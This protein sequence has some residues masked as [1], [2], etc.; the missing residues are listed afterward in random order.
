MTCLS[1]APAVP[2]TFPITVSSITATRN[3]DYTFGTVTVAAGQANA[4]MVVTIIDDDIEEQNETFRITLFVS[5]F[6]PRTSRNINA[7]GGGIRRNTTMTIIDNDDPLTVEFAMDDVLVMEDVGM[8]MVPVRLSSAAT[9]RIT[10]FVGTTA[11]TAT[12]NVDYR[13]GPAVVFE[14]NDTMATASVPIVNDNLVESDET[15]TVNIL[16]GVLPASVTAGARTS[17]T[18]TIDSEDT[19]TVNFS[20]PTSTVDEDTITGGALVTLRLT[21]PVAVEIDIPVM[22]TDGSAMAGTHY[23]DDDPIVNFVAITPAHR[24]SSRSR[25]ITRIIPTGRSR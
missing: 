25:M 23:E 21:K 4:L 6:P 13:S 12:F 1:S 2:L 11:N 16:P 22:F 3:V 9:E 24:F 15:F 20:Q 19:A 17:T 18:V 7:P 8:A 5:M 14:V 10:F